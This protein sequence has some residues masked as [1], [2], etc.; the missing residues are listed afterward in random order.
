MSSTEYYNDMVS[1]YREYITEDRMHELHYLTDQQFDKLIFS[2]NNT[3][4][5][6]NLLDI[7][8]KKELNY[9]LDY[10]ELLSTHNRDWVTNYVLD[11]F[12]KE[13]Q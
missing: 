8:T 11:E 1:T 4:V 6:I 10:S 7:F 9:I 3:N 2:G 5:H 13:E 12:F